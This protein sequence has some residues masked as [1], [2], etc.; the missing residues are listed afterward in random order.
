MTTEKPIIFNGEMVRAILANKKTQTRRVIKPQPRWVTQIIAKRPYAKGMR[1]W[2]R[3]NF[4]VQE[5]LW[6]ENH[7]PQPIEYMADIKHRDQVEDYIGKPSI[8]MPQW[9][10]RITL[11]ITDVRKQRIQDISEE[12]A[13]AEGSYLDRC[14][15][16]SRSKDKTHL[17]AAFSQNWCHVHG[18]EFKHLWNSINEAKGYGWQS[19]PFVWCIE[20]RRIKQND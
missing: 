1:L 5:F 4:Y 12:D 19:N 15:C 14:D 17:D 10:S 3:E 2:V 6:E 7:E 20:F 13:K 16:M 8:H 11:E 18:D 9:A